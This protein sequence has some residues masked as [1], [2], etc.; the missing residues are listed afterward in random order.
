MTAIMFT[1]LLILT[2]LLVL[3]ALLAVSFGVDSRDGDDWST[4]P[5]LYRGK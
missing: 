3:V 2:A 1:G 5:P 4:H